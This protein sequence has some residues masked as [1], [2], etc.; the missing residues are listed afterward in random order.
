M[1]RGKGAWYRNRQSWSVCYHLENHLDNISEIRTRAI[2]IVSILK[3]DLGWEK[4]TGGPNIAES[5]LELKFGDIGHFRR[6]EKKLIL[7][8]K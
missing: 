8:F 4:D 3:M 7:T 2:E 5:F 1:I 6:Y